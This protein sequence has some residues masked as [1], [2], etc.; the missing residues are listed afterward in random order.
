MA[1]S[2]HRGA[3]DA[4]A[5]VRALLLERVAWAHA[6]AGEAASADRALGRVDEA[7]A[8]RSPPDDPV[9]VYWLTPDEVAVMAGRCWTELHRPLRAVP[10]LE[11]ATARYGEDTAR[12]SAL[13]LTWLAEAY[14]Q[15]NE[16]EQGA[17]VALR[18]LDLAC[19]THSARA[20]ERVDQLRTVLAPYRGNAD[21]GTFEDAYQAA[22]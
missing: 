15:A 14:V 10:V 22:Q 18:A 4:P 2:A 13:Y 7:Y 8:D 16:V 9:W 11:T 3:A 20:S 19:R 1:A 21:V 5:T 6:K 12:E 17:Q